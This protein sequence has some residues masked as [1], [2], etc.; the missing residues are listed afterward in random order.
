M[1]V[2]KYRMAINKFN[3]DE[4]IYDEQLYELYGE[5]RYEIVY[6][7]DIYNMKHVNKNIFK[8]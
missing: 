3:H 6:T 7:K 5:P 4:C 8:L 1:I 2:A